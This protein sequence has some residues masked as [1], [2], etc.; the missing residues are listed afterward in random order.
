MQRIRKA[1]GRRHGI[2][3]GAL[4]WVEAVAA[5]ATVAAIGIGII[6]HFTSAGDARFPGEGKRVIAFRQV[7][8]RICTEN[9]DNLQRALVDGHSRVEQLGFVARA[10]GWDVNDLEGVSAPP[11]TFDAFLA[12]VAVRR[13][14]RLE[15]LALQ[16]SIELG[17]QSKE[18][19][20]IAALETL[21]AESR[22]LARQSGILR[23][24]RILPPARE[25]IA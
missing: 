18:A 24:M 14:A 20:A 12:E 6:N 5:I 25:L 16:R 23:C 3:R 9:R 15:V 7:A 19:S 2:T 17:D 8:N 22:E 21:E 4:I 10:I 1:I 11:T 13:R